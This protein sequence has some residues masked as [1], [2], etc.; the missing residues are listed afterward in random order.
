MVRKAQIF[1]TVAALVHSLD[2]VLNIDNMLPYSIK[3][4]ADNREINGNTQ[5]I[6]RPYAEL[7]SKMIN[8]KYNIDNFIDDESRFLVDD[9][10]E[11]RMLL[12]METYL[13]GAVLAKVDRASMKYSLECR[14]P[15]LDY[16]IIEFSQKLSSSL[17]FHNGKGKYFLRSLAHDYILEDLLDRPK[18]G[19]S[20]PVDK[21][22]RG[23][24]SNKLKYYSSY[25]FLR[26]QDIFNV[27]YVHGFLNEYINNGN[28]G[29]G[30]NYAIIC[31]NFFIFQQWYDYYF[32]EMR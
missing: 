4:V 24:F 10:R 20:I 13:P 6:Y 1:D 26:K 30:K 17:K 19:F 3:L 14:S 21:W 16:R 27:D 25:D 11:K 12:D 9:W 32:N 31:W 2:N 28:R 7:I 22:L 18:M 23:Y 5:L 15:I 29:H 8:H